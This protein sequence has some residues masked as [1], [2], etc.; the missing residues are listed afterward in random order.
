M[1]QFRRETNQSEQLGRKRYHPS[2]SEFKRIFLGISKTFKTLLPEV[3][4]EAVVEALKGTSFDITTA[5][6]YLRDPNKNK[7]IAIKRLG[8][9]CGRGRT[10]KEQR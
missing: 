3:S 2:E 4:E 9:Y 6:E 7:S 10:A 1:Q 8:V 5:Y